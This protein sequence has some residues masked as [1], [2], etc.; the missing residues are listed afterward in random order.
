MKKFS[1]YFMVLL[2]MMGMSVKAQDLV[3]TG[4]LDGPLLGGLPKAIEL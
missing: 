1:T 2:M 4:V 3:I